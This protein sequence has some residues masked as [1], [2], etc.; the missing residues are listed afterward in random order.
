MDTNTTT[1]APEADPAATEEAAAAAFAAE[2]KEA[3]TSG[4]PVT[5]PAPGRIQVEM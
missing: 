3:L 4:P 5:E 1:S 2:L